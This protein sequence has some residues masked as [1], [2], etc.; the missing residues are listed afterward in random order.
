MIVFSY[1]MLSLNSLCTKL[2]TEESMC[3]HLHTF[4]D[5]GRNSINRQSFNTSDFLSSDFAVTTTTASRSI[6]TTSTGSSSRPL[7]QGSYPSF[8]IPENDN[9]EEDAYILSRVNKHKSSQ[10]M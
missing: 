7:R 5:I 10:H 3:G 9:E 1:L 6:I 2:S 8:S 4:D